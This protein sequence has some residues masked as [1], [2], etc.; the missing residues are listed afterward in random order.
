MTKNSNESKKSTE[1]KSDDYYF[2]GVKE[3][4]LEQIETEV[5]NESIYLDVFSGSDLQLKTNVTPIESALS[6]VLQLH[7]VTYQWNA[8]RVRENGH[9]PDSFTHAGLI[10][11]EVAS[12]IPELVRRDDK[13]Q[14]LA[15]SYP[16][17]A[18]YLIEAVRELSTQLSTQ[19]E[20][21]AALEKQ[22]AL[23]TPIGNA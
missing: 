16:K 7:G 8:E 21:I 22:L 14:V 18:P 20:K 23:L 1:G 4:N 13:S 11:Q 15:V 12:V 10:A 17:I 9:E 19:N 2:G 3:F 6:K 5:L